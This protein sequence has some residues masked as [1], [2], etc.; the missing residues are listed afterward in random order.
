MLAETSTFGVRY[1]DVDRVVLDREFRR[2]KTPH[3]DV[4]VKIGKLDGKVARVA[5]EYDVCKKIAVKKGLP[6]KKV[7][8]DILRCA[9]SQSKPGSR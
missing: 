6:V 3:G 7:Y 1:Y 8:D 4:S 2:V 5:P 9:E